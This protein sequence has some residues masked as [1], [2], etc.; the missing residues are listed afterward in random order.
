M[1]PKE[2][3]ERVYAAAKIEEVVGD[4]VSLKRRGANLIGLCPFHNE[5]TGSFTVSP[6]KGIYKCFGCGKSGHAVGF[7]MDIEQCSFSDAVKQVAKKYHIEV[8]ERQLTPEEQQRQD[9]RESMFAVN[10]FSN[11]FFQNQLWETEEGKAIGLSYLIGKRGVREDIIRRFQLG[12]SPDRSLLSEALQRAG[13]QER[14]V[15]NDAQNEPHLGTGVCIKSDKDGHWFDRFHSRVIFPF[16]S[17]SGKVIGFAGRILKTNEKV[18]KYVNSPTSPLFEKK[19][20]LYGFF[21]AKQAIQ[22]KDQCILVEGQ[23]DVISMVQ[24]GIENVVS[25][26]GTSLT[27]P[28]IKLMHRFTDN[29]VIVYDGDKAGIHAAL[30]GIDMVLAEGMNVKIVLLPEGQDP[31]EFARSHNADEL[32]AYIER[33]QVDF[34]RFKA[35]LLSEDAGSDPQKRADL[36]N[37]IVNSIAQI[38]DA[39][40]RQVYLKDTADQLH[41][42]EQLL[43]RRLMDLRRDIAAEAEKQR[44]VRRQ[45]EERR[46]MVEAMSVPATPDNIPSDS[47]AIKELPKVPTTKLTRFEENYQN[48]LQV[49]IRHGE[50]TLMNKDSKQPY[51]KTDGTPLT[52][53]ECIILQLRNDCI[54]APNTVFRDIMEEYMRHCQ[55]S[56]FVAET[57]F[58]FHADPNISRLAVELIA[59]KYQLSRIY[60]KQNISENVTQEV[61]TEIDG[62]QLMELVQQLL[63]EIKYT[64]ISQR[65]AENKKAI[66]DAQARGDMETQ[67]TLL[68]AQ[69]QM[70]AI[71]NQISQLLG[72]RVIS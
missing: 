3:L 70:L 71:R 9:D 18:G 62:Y 13:Y 51:L 53:G 68:Q 31:D 66:A 25:S 47:G 42:N 56:G 8:E 15:L 29:L 48:L 4:Y 28:Q 27:T 69:P 24:S 55:E 59:D 17:S 63:L 33:N 61:N 35:Q 26:G 20:E 14:F 37:D 16:F 38:P 57:F 34:I 64:V 60:S 36:I 49:L 10:E 43:G 22:R 30:R 41:I 23:L 1:I 11:Q 39:I 19:N 46:S 50:K 54:D 40:T 5:K 58:K 67:L 2:T 7:V 52:V 65:I 32:L 72:N 6:A 44:N 45:E 12:Y 21:Q